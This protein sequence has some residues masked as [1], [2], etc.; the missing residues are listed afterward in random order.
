VKATVK[1]KVESK[2]KTILFPNSIH[3]KTLQEKTF[4]NYGKIFECSFQ[5]E[6]YWLDEKKGE[7]NLN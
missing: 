6:N 3:T 5:L 7:F 1:S 4:K 2:A